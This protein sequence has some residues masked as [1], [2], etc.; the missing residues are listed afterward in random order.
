MKAYDKCNFWA[1]IQ[2]QS[3]LLLLI[4]KS[5]FELHLEQPLWL[6]YKAPR[7]YNVNFLR[8]FKTKSIYKK[9]IKQ[10]HL[11]VG[12]ILTTQTV[13]LHRNSQQTTG[14]TNRFFIMWRPQFRKRCYRINN[15]VPCFHNNDLKPERGRKNAV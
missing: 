12:D 15:V 10:V 2:S 11:Q 6:F 14:C 13:G 4:T 5:C 9:A 3:L 1:F 7:R 8:R